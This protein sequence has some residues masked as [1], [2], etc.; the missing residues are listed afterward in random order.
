MQTVINIRL[1]SPR[2]GHED[3]YTITLAS[4]FMEITM[5]TRHC[6]CVWQEN[7]DPLWS[8][9]PLIRILQNDSIHPPA[10]I[11]NLFE[12][13]WEEWRIGNIDSFQAEVEL[14]ELA[15]WLNEITKAKPKSEFW[16]KYF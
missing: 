1:F 2:W 12:H 6:K 8:G 10:I 7:T 3:T 15:D 16:K 5:Q 13:L 14:I 4:E 11:Q 9:E